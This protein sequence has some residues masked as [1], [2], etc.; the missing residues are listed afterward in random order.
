[1]KDRASA[2]FRLEVAQAAPRLG[3]VDLDQAVCLVDA[4]DRGVHQRQ[5]ASQLRERHDA[6]GIVVVLL[7]PSLW[8]AD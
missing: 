3:H 2:C 5:D 8:C 4:L 6:V 7:V 1:M